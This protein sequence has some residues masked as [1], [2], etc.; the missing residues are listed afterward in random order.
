MKYKK[1]YCVLIAI[2]LLLGV[3]TATAQN[4]DLRILESINPRYP[5]SQFWKYDSYSAYVFTGIAM[6]GPLIYGLTSGDDAAKHRSYEIITGIALSTIVMEGLKI[7]INRTRPGD[8]YPDL[9]FPVDPAHGQS[10]PSGHT[11]LAFATATE[12]T[13]Q[14]KKW[15]VAVPAFLWAGSVGYSRLYLGKHYPSDVLGGAAVGVGGA[16]ASHWINEKLFKHYYLKK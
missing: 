15:Y 11:S 1:K 9:V 8:R 3:M 4:V 5:N 6:S 7:S 12:L 2:Q 13:I 14:Y 16:L 10:F